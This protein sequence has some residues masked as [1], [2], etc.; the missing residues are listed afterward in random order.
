LRVG[1]T[2]D[3]LSQLIEL[4]E[5]ERE[6]IRKEVSR[7]RGFVPI[8]IKEN[9]SWDEMARIQVN[10]PDLPGIIIDEGLTRYYPQG[11]LASHLMGYVGAVDEADLTG[12]PVLQ[13]PGFKIGK[14][15]V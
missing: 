2:L 1:N 6:R 10:A 13:L 15:G 12:D 9:L 8:T 7:K 11:E 5:N 4:P 3:A 14:E